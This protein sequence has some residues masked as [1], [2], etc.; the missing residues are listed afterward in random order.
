MNSADVLGIRLDATIPTEEQ[1]LERA[2][3][4][5]PVLIE[6]ATASEYARVAPP[7]TIADFRAAGFFRILQPVRWGGYGLPPIT[8]CRVIREL[9]RGDMSAGWISFVLGLHQYEVAVMGERACEAVWGADS[10]AL[11]ASSYAPLGK[12]ERVKGGYRVSGTWR[13]SSGIDYADYAAVGGMVDAG[14]GGGRQYV[15]CLV[16]RTAYKVDPASWNVFGLAGTGSRDF[17]VEGTFVPE[18]LA[19]RLDESPRSPMPRELCYPLWQ[20]FGATLA[21]AVLGGA[22]G[23]LDEFQ[24]GMSARVS[25]FDSGKGR[26]QLADDPLIRA[27]AGRA[28]MLLRGAEYRLEAVMAEIER[29]VAADQSIPLQERAWYRTEWGF[30]SEA[31]TEATLILYQVLGARGADLGS[32]FQSILRNVLVGSN[33]IGLVVDGPTMNAGGML[34]GKEN[35]I[36]TC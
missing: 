30:V 1:L 13:F 36:V 26:L 31:A 24:A 19:H 16:P 10:N 32:R 35:S 14:D 33:H 9:A 8:L 15:A 34:L 29:K 12:I 22:L 17:T 25:S 7:E 23:G 11:V 2:R 5:V 4:L 28:A 27:R 6:R 20:L 18:H 21:S 3:A